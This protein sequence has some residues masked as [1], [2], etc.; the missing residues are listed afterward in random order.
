VTRILVIFLWINRPNFTHTLQCKQYPGK[1]GQ[2]IST[3]CDRPW[4][5]SW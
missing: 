2:T 1:S 4:D 3:Q 5:W